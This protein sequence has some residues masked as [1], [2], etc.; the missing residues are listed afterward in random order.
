MTN[1]FNV[2]KAIKMQGEDT[3]DGAVLAASVGISAN[4]G[5][6]E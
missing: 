3:F 2:N 5:L 6:A 4:T 1:I